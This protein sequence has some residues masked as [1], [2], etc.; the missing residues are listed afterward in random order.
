MDTSHICVL[1]VGNTNKKLQIFDAAYQIVHTRSAQFPERSES[2]LTLEPIEEIMDWFLE[3]LKEVSA[4][5]EIGAIAVSAHGGSFVCLDQ[6]GSLSIPMLFNAHDPGPDFH[7]RFYDK[8]GSADQFHIETSTPP[9]PY[10]VCI[11]KGIAFAKEQFPEAFAQTAHIL[12]LPQYIGYRLTENLA[13]EKTYLGNHTYLW[14]FKKEEFSPF[15]DQ[16]GI[17]H[18]LPKNILSPWDRLG[19]VT[20]A[21]ADATG[22]SVETI[23]IAGIHDSS[24]A[25]IPFSLMDEHPKILSSAGSM[26]VNMIAEDAPDINE[27]DL[28]KTIYYNNG[29]FS[30]L[31]KTVFFAGGIEFDLYRQLIQSIHNRDDIP[32]FNHDLCELVLAEATQFITP[33]ITT[34][35]MF[36]VGSSRAVENGQFFGLDKLF[37]GETPAFFQDYDRA[38]MVLNLSIAIHSKLSI[39]AIRR[40]PSTPV[41]VEGGFHKN[42][43]HTAL[44]AALLPNTQVLTTDVTEV[45]SL[46]AAILARAALAGKS[47]EK[48]TAL[49][50][51]QQQEISC[52]PLINLDRYLDRFLDFANS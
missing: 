19:T 38:F 24:S 7:A 45:T 29:A 52:Q 37:M 36:P 41:Y 18:L 32:P 9:L 50:T 34:M 33:S 22:L 48:L 31:I 26:I 8:F 39:E 11:G 14:D 5:F 46:G 42:D 47:P 12:G 23:V 17:R 27:D 35:G 10:L 4:L 13:L 44:L 43:S 16:L 40:S 49:P 3:G 51:I 6:T 1:D 21:I 2:E 30:K 25:F 20:R 28:G 15:V